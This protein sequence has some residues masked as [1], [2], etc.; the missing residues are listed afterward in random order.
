MTSIPPEVVGGERITLPGRD[1]AALPPLG[2]NAPAP[3]GVVVALRLG[4]A[5]ARDHLLSRATALVVILALALV[6][7]GAAIERAR[8]T[9]GAVDRALDGAFGLVVPLVVLA[10]VGRATARGRLDE[11][12]WPAARFGVA[13]RDVAL[14][15]VVVAAVASALVV[16]V[17][18]ATTVIVAGSGGSVGV[19]R[20]ALVSAWIGAVTALAYVGWLA[21]A[22]TLLPR[23]WGRIVFIV[24]DLLAGGSDGVLGAVLPRGPAHA[25]LGG[26]APLGL[27]PGQCMAILI[28]SAFALS[29]VAAM[30]C[31]A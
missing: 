21:L 6:V 5:M 2:R 4:A 1:P 12:A 18:A 28:A 17:L 16:A 14:G 11:A 22:S 8:T 10:L 30:R 13:R 23:G 19:A 20:D 3:A 9:A 27:A 24:F 7:A 26:A 31:R 29:I 25:L 15:I